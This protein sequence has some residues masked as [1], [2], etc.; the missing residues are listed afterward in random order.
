MLLTNVV[1]MYPSS[2]HSSESCQKTYKTLCT[3]CKIFACCLLHSDFLSA[4]SF[5]PVNVA[6][7]FLRNVDFLCR[8][9]WYYFPKNRGLYFKLFVFRRLKRRLPIDLK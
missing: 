9:T 5:I 2:S 8:I 1:A 7:I 4:M 3:E 6:Y